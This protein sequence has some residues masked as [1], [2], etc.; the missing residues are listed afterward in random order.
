[1]EVLESDCLIMDIAVLK[2]LVALA[3]VCMLLFGSAV[4]FSRGKTAPLFLQLFGAGCLLV[5]ALTH[6][7]EALHLFPW[8][9]WGHEHSVGHYLDFGS[10]LL[11]LTLFPLG[12]LLHAVAK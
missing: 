8:M 10:A 7:F 11:G 12:Y 4:M 3:P 2:A 1:V 5:V 6:V 9:R